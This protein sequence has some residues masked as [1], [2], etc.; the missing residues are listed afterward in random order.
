M[1]IGSGL[2]TPPQFYTHG[3]NAKDFAQSKIHVP[4]MS[5]QTQAP[6]TVQ[7]KLSVL[8]TFLAKWFIN[9]LALS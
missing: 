9:Y 7:M 1:S 5:H 6:N 4:Q 8:Q 2:L 3:L